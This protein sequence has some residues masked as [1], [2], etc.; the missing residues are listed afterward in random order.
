M[1]ILLF[2][3]ALAPCLVLL[4]SL[5][6]RRLGPRLGGRLLGAP[7]TSGPFIAVLCL[8]SGSA[9]A[10][11]AARGGAGGQL[12][13]AGFCIVYGRLAPRCGP[14]L[15][16]V[17][18]LVCVAV[19][20]A[21]ETLCGDDIAVTVALVLLLILVN[22]PAP[23]R[24]RPDPDPNSLSRGA[25]AARMVLSGTVVLAS[26]SLAHL[27]GPVAG[28]MLSAMPVLL[29]V[30]A[31]ALHRCSGAAAVADLLRGALASGSGTVAFLFVLC[32]A[33]VPCGPIAAFALALGA[34]AAIDAVVRR[35]AVRPVGD[36]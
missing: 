8:S 12:C 16:L 6:A 22:V 27:A 35:A 28:G 25:I 4:V 18:S 10:A 7:T 9:A 15:T 3:T 20:G 11:H 14:A 2:R 26:V 30:M 13:V 36:R 21:V 33:L 23:V 32:V 31:P 5:A 17:L 1:E 19:A 24:V 29:I 34:L